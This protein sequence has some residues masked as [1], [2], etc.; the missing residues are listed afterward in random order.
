MT[1][2]L[3]NHLGDRG[4]GRW[5]QAHDGEEECSQRNCSSKNSGGRTVSETHFDYWFI[6]RLDVG[7]VCRWTGLSLQSCM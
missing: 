3:L 4:N 1:T 2:M 5:P 6:E 7:D